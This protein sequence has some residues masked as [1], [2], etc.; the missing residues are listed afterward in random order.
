VNADYLQYYRTDVTGPQ[1]FDTVLYPNKVGETTEVAVERVALNVPTNTASALEI[2][3][4][5]DTGYYYVSHE[6][7]PQ[8][9][10]FGAYE[11]DGQL[12]YTEKD[13]RGRRTVAALSGGKSLRE[14]GTAVIESAE[15]LSDFGAQWNGTTLALF[16]S[17]KLPDTGVRIA[18]PGSVS[19]VTLNGKTIPFTVEN[20]MVQTGKV[21]EPENPGGTMPPSGGS[22]GGGAGG[23]AG[24]PDNQVPVVPSP[25]PDTVQPSVPEF[26]DIEGHWAK[27]QIERMAARGAVN[28][29]ESGVF[30]PDSGVTRAQFAVMLVKAL[31]L[32][33][34]T[35]NGGFTDVSDGDW[36]AP[37]VAAA[38]N[39]QMIDGYGDGSFQ[40]DREISRQEMAK[41]LRSVCAA[42]GLYED[43]KDIRS[44]SDWQQIEPWAAEA[45]QATTG[46]G[47]MQGMDDGTFAPL[48]G[49]TRAQAAVV[50]CRLLD[51]LEREV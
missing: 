15:P 37:Y 25:T 14:N 21:P 3:M 42:Q 31:K 36:F 44:F 49:T 30:Q 32:P 13:Y 41:L 38:K 43:L 50:L 11:T 24:R 48:S 1:T 10:T 8:K 35:G 6:Q 45:V 20:N 4:D 34:G 26:L 17:A 16:S 40:P 18:A 51:L 19:K 23:A 9:R 7:Q 12:A 27:E 5:S 39:A 28:G 22:G 33:A 46:F 47:L 2:T 29:V